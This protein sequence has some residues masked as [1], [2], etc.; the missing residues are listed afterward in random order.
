[1]HFKGRVDQSLKDIEARESSGG[2]DISSRR[3]ATSAKTATASQQ[4]NTVKQSVTDPALSQEQQMVNDSSAT[5]SMMPSDSQQPAVTPVKRIN[6]ASQ[7]QQAP[8]KPSTPL[9]L[10]DKI[11]QSSPDT[12]TTDPNQ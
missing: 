11:R 3:T 1:M 4:A 2:Y 7:I 6:A 12:G 9:V 5:E 10:R 8:P